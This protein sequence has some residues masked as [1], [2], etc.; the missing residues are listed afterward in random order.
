MD[1]DD[2]SAPRSR[3]TDF[4]DGARQIFFRVPRAFHLHEANGEFAGHEF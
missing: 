1:G 4:V 2:L 3:G